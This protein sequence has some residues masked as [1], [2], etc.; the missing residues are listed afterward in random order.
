MLSL[1]KADLT[2]VVSLLKK[3][4][5]SSDIWFTAI[6]LEN[7]FVCLFFLHTCY[8]TESCS[9]TSDSL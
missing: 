9:V 8:E 7:V 4:N 6:E 3:I 1:P 2:D 5:T